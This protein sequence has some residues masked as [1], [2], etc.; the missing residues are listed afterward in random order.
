MHP[1]V[2][3]VLAGY[4]G[5]EAGDIPAA[6]AGLAE[7]VVWTEPAEFPMGGRRVGRAAVA[8]YLRA[9]RASWQH[10]ESSRTAYRSGDRVAVVHTVSGVLLDGTPATVTV[11]D[12]FT[13]WNG[14]AIA[15]TATTDVESALASL[16]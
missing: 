4:A 3:L 10:L 2:D 16:R 15:M 14:E 7:Q 5:F 9:S 11:A 13:V 6:T 1:D 12:V 8:E